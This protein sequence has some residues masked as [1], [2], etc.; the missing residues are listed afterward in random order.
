MPFIREPAWSWTEAGPNVLSEFQ[1]RNC[2]LA[3]L[4]L[5][6]KWNGKAH[7]AWAFSFH[8]PAL[9]RHTHWPVPDS[10]GMFG[11]RPKGG[12]TPEPLGDGGPEPYG[13]GRGRVSGR[14][15]SEG[16]AT[17]SGLCLQRVTPVSGVPACL[18]AGLA[19]SHGPDGRW[20]ESPAPGSNGSC[21]VSRPAVTA[22]ASV[23]WCL[24]SAAGAGSA[25][26]PAH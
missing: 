24:E 18:Q 2:S 17:T 3:Y 23:R 7:L 25:M 19:E 9:A 8:R 26:R 10:V 12:W 11:S 13:E 15:T 21:L 1:G 22:P 16:R 4:Q 14:A 20:L 5:R 6:A